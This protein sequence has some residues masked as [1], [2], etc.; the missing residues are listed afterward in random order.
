M[1]NISEMEVFDA[2]EDEVFEIVDAIRNLS[3]RYASGTRRR[4]I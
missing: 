3:G 1:I 2:I 4:Y